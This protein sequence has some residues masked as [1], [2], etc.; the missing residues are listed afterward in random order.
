MAK[1]TLVIWMNGR[2]VGTWTQTRGA[3]LLQYDSEWVESPE[4]RALS[5]SLPFTPGNTS[6]RGVAV[7][8][9][10]DNL[11]PDSDVIRARLRAKFST[12]SA[13]AFDLLTAI[14]R[15]CVGAV[16][17]LP[18]DQA[19][20]G[21]DRI[22]AEPLTDAGVEGAIA[23]SLSGARVMGQS[24]VDE[25]RISLAG[26]QEKTALLWHRGKWCR[27][28]GATPT[29]HIL[30]LPLG[31]VGHLQMDMQNSVENEWLCLR[32]MQA[33]DLNTAG[34]EIIQFGQRKVL[35]VE[36]FDRAREPAGWL[37]RL[38]QEDFCQA[39]GLPGTKKYESD[40][41]PGM[42]EIL[43]VLDASA[44]P[45]EDKRAFIKAQIVFWMLAA[46]D[47]HAKNFSIFHGRGGAYRLTP[48]YD[49]L[50][51]WPIMGRGPNLLDER[52]VRLAMAVRGKNAHWKLSEIKARHWDAV[53]RVAGLGS[54]A[55]LL[56]EIVT[57]TPGAIANVARQTPARFP[58]EVQDKIF[59]G[60]QRAAARLADDY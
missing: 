46:T 36:R 21:F 41:G 53:T 49:V 48:F 33:F 50:S 13:E 43:R 54:A 20:V 22:E 10:F 38:P 34:C 60:L 52:K 4:G 58:A 16:Q 56:A 6:H 35:A 40:G 19:P 45:V 27:P 9:F 3:H 12:S 47:G 11:L 24:G 30:K 26:A 23:A 7:V 59:D 8:S 51:A 17:L 29:T 44:G 15:D 18:D 5:L 25:F 57:R 39:L 14:G 31:L 28:L 37:A 1:S 42:R 55:P 2:R 32:L